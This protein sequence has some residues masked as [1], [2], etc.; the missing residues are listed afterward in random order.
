MRTRPWEVDD[1]LWSRVEPLIPPVPPR[2]KGGRPRVPDRRVFAAIMYVLRTGAQWNALPTD[3]CSSSVAHARFQEWERAGFFRTLWEEGLL[4]YDEVQGINWEWQ[5][6]DGAMT[7]SPFGGAAT[8][9]N[10]TDRGKSGVKRSLMTDADG[11]P[12][13]LVVDGANRHDSKLLKATVEAVVVRR[14]KPTRNRPQHM[15]LDK[16]YDY[17][18]VD[19]YLEDKKYVAHISRIGTTPRKKRRG[20]RAR[21]WV[22]ERTHSWINRS[23]R[24]LVRW[25]K[26]VENYEAFLALACALIIFAKLGWVSG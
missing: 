23:R 21:R 12:L 11:I 20:E 18:V 6:I 14:P 8:G 9:A 17:P 2:P 3:M 1:T 7:K 25:E 26:K 19:D 13:A 10:P 5:S 4:E 24:L 16:G 22:V 15:C